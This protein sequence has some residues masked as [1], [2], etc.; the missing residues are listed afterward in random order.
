MGHSDIFVRDLQ[1]G[2]TTLVSVNQAGT[3]SGNGF[4]EN[5][6]ISADG[7]FVAFVSEA[8][9]L[10]A[11]DTNGQPDVF[12]RDLQAGTTALVSVNQAGTASGNGRSEVPVISADGRFVAFVS[13]ASDLVADDNNDRRDVFVRPVP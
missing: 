5:P 10:V 1:S 7:R 4:S 11:S 8:S 6:L 3:A 12:V 13:R 2:T 9:D